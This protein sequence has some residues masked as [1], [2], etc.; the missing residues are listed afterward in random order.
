M[1]EICSFICGV[2][3]SVRWSL[4]LNFKPTWMYPL[5]NFSNGCQFYPY[6][7][8]KLND[9]LSESF[10][11]IVIKRSNNVQP[12]CK[13]TFVFLLNW[14]LYGCRGITNKVRP[15]LDKPIKRTSSHYSFWRIWWIISKCEIFMT[16]SYWRR[17]VDFAVQK[18][19]LLVRSVISK[20]KSKLRTISE[21]IPR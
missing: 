13:L 20:V 4:S 18:P 1:I 21:F 11:E 17:A 19:L 7:I 15:F 9:W 14:S 16:T 3:Y 10:D 5:G 6:I 8:P 12:T 2:Y